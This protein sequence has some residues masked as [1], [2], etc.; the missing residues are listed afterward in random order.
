VVGPVSSEERSDAAFR[1][2]VGFVVLVGLSSGLISLQGDL[3]LWGTG[4][5]ILAGLLLGVLLVWVVFPGTGEI[6]SSRRGP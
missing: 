4:V 2:K 5:A 3:P 1:L 6:S